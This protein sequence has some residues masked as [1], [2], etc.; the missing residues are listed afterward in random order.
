MSA[1][2]YLALP[3][4]EIRLRDGPY[5]GRTGT[6][7]SVHPDKDH[8]AENSLVVVKLLNGRINSCYMGNLEMLQPAPQ[9]GS[10]R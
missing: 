5:T 3:G 10:L 9:K 1:E 8:S 2:N 4:D 6:V 7:V